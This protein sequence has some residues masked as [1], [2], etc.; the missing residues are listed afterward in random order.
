LLLR[1]LQR[2]Q[3]KF[4]L[5]IG[6]NLGSLYPAYWL[7]KKEKTKFAFDVEDYHPIDIG[8]Y[9]ESLINIMNM[10]S[11]STNSKLSCATDDIPFYHLFK[12][13]ELAAFKLHFWDNRISKQTG[14][15]LSTTFD[16]KKS[17]KQDI[18]SAY[19]L[20]KIYQSIPSVEIWTKSYLL[21]TIDQIRYAAESNILKD[22]SLGRILCEQLIATLYDI[23]GYAMK[24]CKN[25]NVLFDWYFCDVVGSVTYLA[26][27]EKKR[28][29][30]LRFNT[31]NNFQSDDESLCNEVDM[32]LQSL[33]N[34]ATGF[35]GQGSKQRNIYLRDARQNIEKLKEMF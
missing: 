30:F 21:I 8:K 3:E 14:N 23:E 10:L 7:A 4:D 29:C 35:S 26:E 5:I 31:F 12:Y 18:K 2:K 6:H 11:E 28:F 9:L 22:K 33:L 34:D 1:K 17:N 16:F 24:S 25:E 20:Y 19:A 15:H 32:W 13:P 27:I